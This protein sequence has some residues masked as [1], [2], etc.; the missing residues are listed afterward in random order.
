MRFAEE[1]E[2]L[3]GTDFAVQCGIIYGTFV[4]GARRFQQIETLLVLEKNVG[5]AEAFEFIV[6]GILCDIYLDIGI[7]FDVNVMTP[8][9]LELALIQPGPLF[10]RVQEE[11]ICLYGKEGAIKL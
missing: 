1:L 9:K 4:K 11:G 10:H 8:E 6:D 5:E 2:K 3:T 7:Y